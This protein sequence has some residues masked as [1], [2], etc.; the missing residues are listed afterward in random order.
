[1]PISLLSSSFPTLHHSDGLTCLRLHRRR[2]LSNPSRLKQRFHTILDDI[3]FRDRASNDLSRDDLG[4]FCAPRPEEWWWNSEVMRCKEERAE[5]HGMWDGVFGDRQ[6]VVQNEEVQIAK[7]EA[8]MN[9]VVPAFPVRRRK[10]S[11]AHVTMRYQNRLAIQEWRQALPNPAN[12]PSSVRSAQTT[13]DCEPIERNDCVPK[14]GSQATT[15][16]NGSRTSSGS[17][18][19]LNAQEEQVFFDKVRKELPAAQR[20]IDSEVLR[21]VDRLRE[22]CE[23]LTCDKWRELKLGIKGQAEREHGW[24][25]NWQFLLRR[26]SSTTEAGAEGYG[27]NA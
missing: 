27:A 4:Y 1:M 8:E 11:V 22:Q 17:S 9:E 21:C 18:I 7:E 13:T 6:T 23:C 15:T 19:T 20:S 25:V 10:S 26:K 24:K 14:I 2:T 12:M 5:R 16:R 3:K